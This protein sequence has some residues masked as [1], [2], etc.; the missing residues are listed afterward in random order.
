MQTQVSLKQKG[1]KKTHTKGDTPNTVLRNLQIHVNI[2]Q[3][4][5]FTKVVVNNMTCNEYSC[6]KLEQ[7]T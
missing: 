4:L 2:S 5:F 3:I 6:I 1:E 7:D